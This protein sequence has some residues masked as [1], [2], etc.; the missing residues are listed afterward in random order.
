MLYMDRICKNYK[1]NNEFEIDM[2]KPRRTI[3]QEELADK[4]K[5]RGKENMISPNRSKPEV[6]KLV[7]V[8]MRIIT[9]KEGGSQEQCQCTHLQKT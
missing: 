9:T 6:T 3:L 7:V 2:K 1:T 8:K 5:I 4:E